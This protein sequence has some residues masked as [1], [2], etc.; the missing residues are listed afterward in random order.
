MTDETVLLSLFLLQTVDV[1]FVDVIEAG[2]SSLEILQNALRSIFD[3]DS[4][5]RFDVVDAHRVVQSGS[6]QLKKFTEIRGF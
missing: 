5:D 1:G 3:E 4:T 2:R 6:F